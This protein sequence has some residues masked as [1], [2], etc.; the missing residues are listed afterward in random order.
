[1]NDKNAF[2]T[3][4]T[5]IRNMQ[6]PII[7]VNNLVGDARG[8]KWTDTHLIIIPNGND[9]VTVFFFEEPS[10]NHNNYLVGVESRQMTHAQA[11]VHYGNEVI[12]H[13]GATLKLMSI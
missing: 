2:E 8:E 3:M 6:V 7:T 11:L 4:L 9:M 10:H 12:T 5:E 1:M 13:P